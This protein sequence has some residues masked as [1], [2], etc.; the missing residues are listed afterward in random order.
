MNVWYRPANSSGLKAYI[1]G[2][3]TGL[4]LENYPAFHDAAKDLRSW[5]FRVCS[6]AETSTVIAQD[7]KLTHA[8]YL[9]F[10][11]Y[12]VL[13]ADVLFVLSGYRIS[14]GAKF[15]IFLAR[16][17]GTP[18]YNYEACRRAGKVTREELLAA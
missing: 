12:R 18:V 4:E 8:Q 15:E 2:P 16:H 9:H 13:E 10:D 7:F 5:G 1:S 17:V 11:A 3:M 14:I 6:P